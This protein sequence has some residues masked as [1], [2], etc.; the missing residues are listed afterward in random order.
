MNTDNQSNTTNVRAA[1][2]AESVLTFV[3]VVGVLMVGLLG[4]KMGILDNVYDI[5]ILLIISLVW[6]TLMAIK[7]GYTF[8]RCLDAMGDNLKKAIT[9][10]FI[11]LIIGA[12]VASWISSGTVP[13]MIYYGSKFLT[14]TIFLPAGFILC[15]IV[16]LSTGTSWG[17]IGTVGLA[18]LGMGSGLGIPDYVVAGAV[19]SGAAFGDKISP[20]SDTTVLTAT[21][22]GSEL[23]ADVRAMMMTTIPAV[24]ISAIGFAFIGHH[25]THSEH[26]NQKSIIA[27]QG[28]LEGHFDL[29]LITF[30][31][32]LI[33]VVLSVMRKPA[34]PVLLLGV[35][36]GGLVAITLQ[37]VDLAKEFSI[38]NYGYHVDTEVKAYAK[39][40]NR[41]GIQSMAWTLTL[42]LIALCLG[43][44]LALANFLKILMQNIL[45]HVKSA[46]NTMTLTF[47]SAVLGCA[48]VSEPYISIIL[49]GNLFRETYK[50][51]NLAPSLASRIIQEG[52]T[53]FVYLIPWTTSSAFAMGAL[54]VNTW[55]YLPYALLNY[56]DP[57]LSLTLGYLGIFVLRPKAAEA[58]TEIT[59]GTT[60]GTTSENTTEK[61]A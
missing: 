30:F 25:F 29:S 42:A 39:L 26:F 1:T 54:S 36:L 52:A 5:H 12:L 8:E 33:V 16:S 18:L 11:F 37:G 14:P 60:S 21:A 6:S 44:V 51:R 34:A 3:G 15:C 49:N 23:Y 41:G 7:V 50:E 53:V 24:I 45:R 59:S 19:L 40:F 28:F 48:A 56:I 57:L 31:P 10:I 61:P 58:G 22:T 55:D 43:G 38:L 2:F 4:K 46:A 17:T 32:L 47:F 13:T 27:L 20:I 35:V 9:G